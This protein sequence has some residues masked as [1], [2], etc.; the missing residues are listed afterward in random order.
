MNICTS[1]DRQTEQVRLCAQHSAWRTT[2]RAACL[3]SSACCK[4]QLLR[5][6]AIRRRDLLDLQAIAQ[7]EHGHMLP[8]PVDE[9][10]LCLKHTWR[11]D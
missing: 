11:Y 9:L 6:Q 7:S 1:N 2:Q 10:A 8:M 3:E 4:D 5:V